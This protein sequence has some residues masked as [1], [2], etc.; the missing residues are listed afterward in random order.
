VIVSLSVYTVNDHRYP[1]LDSQN[2][3][4]LMSDV[5]DFC[6]W[7]YLKEKRPSDKVRDSSYRNVLHRQGQSLKF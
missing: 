2:S 3:K 6:G 1:E 4:V 7:Y 5:D